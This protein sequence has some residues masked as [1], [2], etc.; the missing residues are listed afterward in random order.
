MRR[1]ILVADNDPR[2]A[3]SLRAALEPRWFAV[4]EAPD[5]ISLLTLLLW[6]PVA[7]VVVPPR[8]AG[9]RR[10]S[11]TAFRLLRCLG[12][13][14]PF[15]RLPAVIFTDASV[16]KLATRIRA[17]TAGCEPTLVSQ[18][19]ARFMPSVMIPTR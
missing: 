10:V 13:Q 3:K 12:R 5:P 6:I 4:V 7:L 11:S 1:T 14:A 15:A 19:E 16:A 18:R 17:L 8:Q 2:T 9:S